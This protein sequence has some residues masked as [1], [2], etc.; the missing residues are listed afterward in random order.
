MFRSRLL[1][2]FVV[3]PLLMAGCATQPNQA[4]TQQSIAE[5]RQ[6]SERLL[7]E[8]RAKDALITDR[9]LNRY[10]RQIGKRIDDQRPPGVPRM[11]LHIVKNADIN[12]FTTGGGYV[13]INAGMIAAMENEAQLATVI[14]HELAHVD[15]GHV[16]AGKQNRTAIGL[17]GVLTQ[18]GLGVA[19]ISGPFVNAGISLAGTAAASTY[20]RSQET[21]ADNVGFEY[22]ADAGYNLV[23]GAR[24]FE[25]LRRVYGQ[26]GGLF[27][28]H[29][30]SSERQANLTRLA[31][32]N[33]A[34]RGRIN[35][36][37]Y[38]RRT[39]RLRRDVTEFLEDN[40]RRREAEQMRRNIRALRG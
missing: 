3:L 20:N 8:L 4:L 28:S 19:G 30:L 1:A 27:A 35:K 11:Q 2:A 17:L 14:G 25:V 21:D 5:E 15:R 6:T 31:Q 40:G 39:N 12:A 37:D 36:R 33:G 32:Q 38:L 16:A 26:K 22:A 7:A 34:D 18:V 10:I 24:A 23:E 9:A 29:P 13:F